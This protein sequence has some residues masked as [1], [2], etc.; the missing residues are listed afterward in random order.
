[1]G[2][3]LTQASAKENNKVRKNINE[4]KARRS[5][6]NQNTP[7]HRAFMETISKKKYR[8]TWGER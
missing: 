3:I 8:V 5:F 2:E 4:I 7:L 6:I 1:M